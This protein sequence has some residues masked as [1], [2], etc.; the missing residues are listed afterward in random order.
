MR[1]PHSGR[2]RRSHP[3][4]RFLARRVAAA[5]A[6][7]LVVSMLVFAGTEVLPGDAAT[8]VLGKTATPAQVA[9]LRKDMGLE[10]SIPVR[11]ADWLTGFVQ[12]DLGDSAAGYAAGGAAPHLGPGPP[13]ARR[14]RSGSPASRRCS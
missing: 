10:R 1:S 13:E 3:I 11:Y 6:T 4:A 7:L 14:R 9:Q 2:V 8:A 12:G 5:I